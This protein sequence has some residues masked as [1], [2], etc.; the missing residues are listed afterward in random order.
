MAITRQAGLGMNLGSVV[1]INDPAPPS[2]GISPFNA[3]TGNQTLS[4]GEAWV[5]PA[6]QYYV[7]PGTV[8]ALQVYD[9]IIGIW[10][11]LGTPTNDFKFITTDGAN[12]RIANQSGCAVGAVITN[13]GSG[14]TSAPTVSASSGS[15]LWRA[16][17]GGSIS[18]TITITQAGAGYNY[19]PE[20]W[21]APPPAGGIPA[22]AIATLSG[23]VPSFTVINQGAGYLTAPVIRIT[24][25]SRE[26][27]AAV[28]GPTTT[29][30]ATT[31]LTGAGTITGLV[32]TN[33]GNPVTLAYNG[34]YPT[35]IFAGGGGSSAAATPLFNWAATGITVSSAGTGYSNN[36][37]FVVQG[38]QGPLPTAAGSLN[39]Q[40]NI[41]LLTPRMSQIVGNTAAGTV[42]TATGAVVNDPGAI[43]YP[44]YV[45][46]GT[47]T[48]TGI[49]VAGQAAPTTYGVVGVNLGG[50]TD[51]VGL[52]TF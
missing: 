45:T 20:V 6:G 38:F 7:D 23:G 4:A 39:P 51:T 31:T 26:S 18:T 48:N 43:L 15:S 17:V 9:P 32:C 11:Q 47:V 33:H 41:N 37:P 21:I 3:N 36:V 52:Y 30:Y 44:A 1:P 16:I 35:L 50:V 49:T 28:P 12:V 25:D 19:P 24:P 22:T 29:T 40:L 5:L 8:S 10:L 14:Y 34:T 27:L 46:G 42:L 13:A 2:G